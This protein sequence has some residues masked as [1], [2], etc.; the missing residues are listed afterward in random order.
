MARIR[1]IKPDF[2]T[3]EQ[4]SE[5]SPNARLAFI[6]LW[7][8][9]DDNGIHPYS[10][11]RIK[12]EVFPSDGFSRAEVETMVQELIAAGLL[13]SYT[14][15]EQ[16]FLRVTGWA[17]HQRIDQPTYKFPLP[18]GVIPQNIRRMSAEHSPDSATNVHSGNGMD[19]KKQEQKAPTKGNSTIAAKGR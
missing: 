9:A 6:G 7:C 10:A 15:G 14:V 18:G 2:F 17:K 13:D 19:R 16:A 4:L 3:S 5:C 8:F 11:A 12:M 1:T